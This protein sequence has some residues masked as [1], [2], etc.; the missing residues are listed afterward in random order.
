[1]NFSAKDGNA[2]AK[3]GYSVERGL[4]G[5]Y[6]GERHIPF[7][8]PHP[9]Y[10]YDIL[11]YNST[12]TSE[13]VNEFPNPKNLF[14][15]TGSFDAL[16]T[17]NRTPRVRISFIGASNGLTNL[18]HGGVHFVQ[19]KKAEE[20][21]SLFIEGEH[22]VFQIAEL[23]KLIVGL[24]SQIGRV[25]FFFSAPNS[26]PFYQVAAL[27][28]RDGKTISAYGTT[29]ESDG[30][31]HYIL[32]PEVKNLSQT[33]IQ[34]LQCLEKTTPSL[35]PDKFNAAWLE[36][37]EFLLPEEREKDSEIERTI[38]DTLA[39][40]EKLREQRT[41]ITKGNT[42]IRRLLVATEDSRIEAAERLSSVVRQAL[43]FLE[44]AVEDIDA[45]TKSAI[46]KEDFWI[47]DGDFLGITEV[48]GTV[49]TNPKV[50]E[51]NAILGRMAT[52][53]KRQTD[54]MLPKAASVSGLLVLNY[55]IK[56]HPD[57]RPKAYTGELE[58]IVQSAD[59]NGIGLLSSVE[60]H[61]IV[62]AVKEGILSKVDARNL[63][64][65][66]GRIEFDRSRVKKV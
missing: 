58:H 24:K 10:E 57:R 64:K 44:F 35:F 63:L 20:N 11:F 9:L 62:V 52:L 19:L 5:K 41:E 46:K 6:D 60:L 13:V 37:D 30:H 48:T 54:L 18:L 22:D 26:Y 36:S 61:K 28:S 2:I 49:H 51:F 29:Y 50:Q 7:E 12:F 39:I 34:I 8:A 16:S 3:A 45:K 40:V 33:V 14:A 25:G 43:E 1:L 55:D 66:S 47:R 42:F 32:L 59:E 27:L 23:H 17:L 31:P 56:N 21:V 4:L 38:S 53:Y 65:K 15:E